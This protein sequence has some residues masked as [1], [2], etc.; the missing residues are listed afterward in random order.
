[1]TTLASLDSRMQP[2]NAL[3]KNGDAAASTQRW[4]AIDLGGLTTTA[5]EKARSD[6]SV[7]A[8]FS[9]AAPSSASASFRFLSG[10]STETRILTPSFPML[11]HGR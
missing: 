2:W 11:M 8:I 1:M 4:T 7:L 10:A 6:Q 9:A 5:S 3:A